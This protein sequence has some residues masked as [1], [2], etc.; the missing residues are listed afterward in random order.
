MSSIGCGANLNTGYQRLIIRI[1]G[2]KKAFPC[3]EMG[4]W[5]ATTPIRGGRGVPAS[6]TRLVACHKPDSRHHEASRVSNSG[7][8]QPQTQSRPS[9]SALRLKLGLWPATSSIS[10]TFASA[11]GIPPRHPYAAFVVCS[12][13]PFDEKVCILTGW[14]GETQ[15]NGCAPIANRACFVAC[16]PAGEIRYFDA[17]CCT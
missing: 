5:S 14:L 2:S 8:G 4:L 17:E 7:C 11:R 12:G 6:Q 3:P 15:W 16:I 9:W 10:V 1:M 13:M